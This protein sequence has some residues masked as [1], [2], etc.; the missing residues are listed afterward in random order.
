MMNGKTQGMINANPES[1]GPCN[2]FSQSRW[3][4][5]EQFRISP[6]ESAD[7]VGVKSYSKLAVAQAN[8]LA[9]RN[10]MSEAEQAYR[11]A[12]QIYPGNMEAAIGLSEVLARSGRAAEANLMLDQFVHDHPNHRRAV[13]NFRQNG[14]RPFL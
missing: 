2:G 4:I 8:L 11:I 1:S 3:T 13:E 12:T 5:A 6:D 9:D 14:V 7:A 10:F